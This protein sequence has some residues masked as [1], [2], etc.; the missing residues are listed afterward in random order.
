MAEMQILKVSVFASG[1]LLLNGLPVSL[2][3]LD[4]VFSQAEAGKSVVW[5][6]R[7]NSAGEPPPTALEV[8]KLITER[9]LPIR[10]ASR[11][12][13]SDAAEMLRRELNERLHRYATRRFKGNSSS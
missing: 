11:P 3:K 5:Y 2:A 1:D 12:D 4:E 10:L 13:F 8:M 7:D 6:Y 9:R